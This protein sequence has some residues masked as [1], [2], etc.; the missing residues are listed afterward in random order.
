MNPKFKLCLRERLRYRLVERIGHLF[1]VAVEMYQVILPRA[2]LND[3]Q[4]RGRAKRH[5]VYVVTRVPRT[6]MSE[7]EL[8]TT[9]DAAVAHLDGFD[10]PESSTL[11]RSTSAR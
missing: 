2:K 4:L 10:I 5:A 3:N 8:Y 11:M 9:N 1:S 7:T 6:K